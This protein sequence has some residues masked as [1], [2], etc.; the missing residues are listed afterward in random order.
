MPTKQNSGDR[1]QT[2]DVAIAIR[3]GRPLRPADFYRIIVA[4][5][6]LHNRDVE[7][8]DP[9]PTGRQILQAASINEVG[10]Y[11]IFAILPSGEFEDLRL[12]ET[13]DLR[14][15]G[16]ERFVIFKSDRNFKFTIN[17]RQLEWGKP[18]IS[19]ATLHALANGGQHEAI[20]LEVLGG[21]DRLIEPHDLVD[22]NA[23]GIEHFI[24]G[25]KPPLTFEIMVNSRPE[26]VNDRRVTFEQV[27]QLAFLGPHGPNIV[28]SMTY[29][30][31]ASEPHAGE[32]GASGAVEVKKKGTIFNVTKTDKS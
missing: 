20:F 22:L 18:A 4:D 25:P 10:D 29:R 6:Q 15:R 23:P 9:V 17:D 27:V 7:V 1:L 2:E 3:E 26:I 24:T 21:T 30:H 31:A 28:F 11:S 32:L 12:D 5:E 8:T 16:A 19:G 13:Y 14:G